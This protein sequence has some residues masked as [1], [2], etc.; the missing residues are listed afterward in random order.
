[1]EAIL[2][3]LFE[4]TAKARLLKLFLMN[5]EREFIMLEIVKQTQLKK[6]AVQ[7]ELAKLMRLGLVKTRTVKTAKGTKAARGAKA[8]KVATENKGEQKVAKEETKR[9]Q[10]PTKA[11][12]ANKKKTK[13]PKERKTAKAT[14]KNNQKSKK[15]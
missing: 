13:A 6:P 15:R 4:S 5:P 8:K 3:K 7:K 2:D 12:K 10:I 1:M 9:K 11:A 14:N